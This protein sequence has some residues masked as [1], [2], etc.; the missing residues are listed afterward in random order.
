MKT[1]HLERPIKKLGNSSGVII[2]AA[3]MRELGVDVSDIVEL[4]ITP[5]QKKPKFDINELMANTDF[6]AQRQDTELTDWETMP[7]AGREVV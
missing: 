7:V 1:V 5:K 4:D 3:T 2:P 6:D